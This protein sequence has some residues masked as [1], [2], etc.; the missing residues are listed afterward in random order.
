MKKTTHILLLFTIILSLFSCSKEDDNEQPSNG[1][2]ISINND[3][4]EPS[5]NNTSNYQIELSSYSFNSTN[6]EP[7][8]IQFVMDIH[9]PDKQYIGG[10]GG[11]T[12]CAELEVFIDVFRTDLE[13]P[14]TISTIFN[15]YG[16]SKEEKQ[17]KAEVFIRFKNDEDDVIMAGTALEN[18]TIN[19][20]NE[21]GE[22]VTIFE[23]LT[24]ESTDGTTNFTASGRIIAN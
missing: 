10:I 19:V 9:D 11:I 22:Y 15:A 23:N 24:F 5:L 1:V 21:N 13:S 6:R 12:T 3:L 20:K 17:D 16:Q 8:G 4:R 18:Q 2:F 14:K 7:S